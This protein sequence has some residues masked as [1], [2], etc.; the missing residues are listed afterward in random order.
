MIKIKESDYL[1]RECTFSPSDWK[2]L[3]GF[4]FPI[5]L[6]KDIGEKPHPVT[7]LDERLIVYRVSAGY[8]V[9]KDLCVHRGS[10]LSYGSVEGD[11]IVCGY[12]GYHYGPDG[13][14]TLVPS[15]PDMN[16]P[17]KLCI[18]VYPSEERY[19]VIWTCLSGTP[20]NTIPD[21]QREWVDKSFRWFTWGPHIWDC[22][23]GRAIENF[24]D[25][26]HFSFVHRGTFGQ[27]SSARMEDYNL[28]HHDDG[29]SME[30]GYMANNPD[31]SPIK[32][33]EQIQRRMIRRLTYPFCTASQI[34]YPEGREHIIHITVIPVSAR[35]SQLLFLF[36]RNFD[37]DVPEEE[38][39]AWEA[40]ILTEDKRFIESQKPEEIPLDLAAEVH[41]RAD[42]ASVAMR[43]WMIDI[44]L[45]R[46][47]TA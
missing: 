4:W 2:V 29:F 42:K 27:E 15:D 23:P 36:S 18:Q 45:G 22:S 32:G 12:H 34:Y 24:V 14:C 21:W 5:A 35:K 6:S 28:A 16:I 1:P 7:L 38:L 39:I 37:R 11:E 19:G 47:F 46:D 44:G 26:A 13:R 33:Q 3:S 20:R 17:E 31:Q 43:R 8:V 41:V 10:P 25:T 9:A 40:R 30:F